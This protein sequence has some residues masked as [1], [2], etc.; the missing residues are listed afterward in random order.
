MKEEMDDGG[1][2]EGI[3]LGLSQRRK[4]MSERRKGQNKG[5]NERVNGCW[6]KESRN[7]PGPNSKEERN[8]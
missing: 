7:M 1:W 5:M 8:E 6:W 2:K 4:G 3:D